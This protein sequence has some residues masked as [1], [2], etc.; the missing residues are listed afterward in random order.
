MRVNINYKYVCLP[1]LYSKTRLL[2]A[3]VT[4]SAADSRSWRQSKP[5]LEL[6]PELFPT[7]V[8]AWFAGCDSGSNEGLLP[9]LGVEE[10]EGVE[11]GDNCWFCKEI[12]FIIIL[13]RKHCCK[14]YVLLSFSLILRVESLIVC[15][16]LANQ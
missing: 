13:T 12:I 5:T 3:L 10:D 7:I 4:E 6:T 11:R 15:E 2:I 14:L 16:S 9:R 1:P 8:L